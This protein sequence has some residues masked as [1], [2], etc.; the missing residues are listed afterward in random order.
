MKRLGGRIESPDGEQSQIDFGSLKMGGGTPVVV[1]SVVLTYTHDIA[2][3]IEQ[4][5]HLA[6]GCKV[7]GSAVAMDE[8]A[9]P[10]EKLVY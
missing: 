5:G 7:A 6:F 4:I 1:E 10:L 3:T 8:G 9:Q 2:A